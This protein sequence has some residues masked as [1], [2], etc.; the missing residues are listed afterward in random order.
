MAISYKSHP[1]D[2]NELHEKLKWSFSCAVDKSEFLDNQKILKLLK[3]GMLKVRKLQI[4]L[5][6]PHLQREK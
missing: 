1:N 2:N 4:I 3:D 6:I 5:L